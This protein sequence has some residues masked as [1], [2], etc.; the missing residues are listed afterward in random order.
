VDK[1]DETEGKKKENDKAENA[2]EEDENEED[3]QVE[4]GNNVMSEKG[5]RYLPA[6][7]MNVEGVDENTNE[8]QI[9]LL[10]ENIKEEDEEQRL[11]TSEESEDEESDN[12]SEEE[13]VIFASSNSPDQPN[14]MMRGDKNRFLDW[15][16]TTDEDHK[17]DLAKEELQNIKNGGYL[18]SNEICR[19]FTYLKGH[20]KQLCKNFLGRKPLLYHSTDFITF[21]SHGICKY[22]KKN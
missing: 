12:E 3:G 14:R 7:L 8:G 10:G 17:I 11:H 2:D 18:T 1:K 16:L 13:G 5:N 9:I 21:N 6:P 22:L 19:Y 4:D 20:D 15:E